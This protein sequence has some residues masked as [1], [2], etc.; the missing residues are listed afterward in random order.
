MIPASSTPGRDG[1]AGVPRAGVDAV[2]VS[3]N[4]RELLGRCL[5]ALQPECRHIIV[6]DAASTDGSAETLAAHVSA[7]DVLALRHNRGFGAAA[8][9]G[10]AAATSDFVLLLNADA[11]PLPGAVAKLVTKA[12]LDSSIGVMAPRLLNPDGSLQRSIFGYPRTPLSLAAWVASPAVISNAFRAWRFMQSSTASL[13]HDGS[14]AIAGGDFPAGA[15]LL[16]RKEAWIEV[17]GF[18][19]AFF[20]YSEETDFCQRLRQLDWKVDL[21]PAASFVHVGA[22]STG[23]VRGAMDREQLRSYVRF[24]AKHHG[25]AQADRA[26]KLIAC[27]LR[28]RA[29]TTSGGQRAHYRQLAGWLQATELRVIL[30]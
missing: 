5:A 14:H 19:E 3:H 29:L 2:V 15:A 17:D 16:I 20:M 11:W 23:Q 10:I 9:A 12:A 21:C 18:D 30:A 22:A 27:A 26:R 25:V 24:F 7:D 8:N 28:V 1:A 13:L 4:T 6:V